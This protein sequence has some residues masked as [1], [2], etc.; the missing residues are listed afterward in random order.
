MEDAM[1]MYLRKMWTKTV[2]LFE[3]QR[4][5]RPGYSCDIQAINFSQYIAV[6][7]DKG[8][9]VYSIIID[10]SKAFGLLPDDRLLTNTAVSRIVA[11]IRGS[12]LGHT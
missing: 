5:S 7:L 11:C 10:F 1:A 8:G 3:G 6:S 12:L 9:T 2:S 4:G